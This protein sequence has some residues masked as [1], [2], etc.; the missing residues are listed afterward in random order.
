MHDVLDA[1]HCYDTNRDETYLRRVIHPLEK[2]LIDHKRIV[3]KDSAV[4]YFLLQN[5]VFIIINFCFI[6]I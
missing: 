3:V 6:K 1:Q 2:L 4:S 5:F